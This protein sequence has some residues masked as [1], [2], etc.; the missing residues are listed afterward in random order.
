M[1]VLSGWVVELVMVIWDVETVEDGGGG[2][3]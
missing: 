2:E 3:A 1:K